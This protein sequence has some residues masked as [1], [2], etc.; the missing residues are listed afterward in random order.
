MSMVLSQRRHSM[1]VMNVRSFWVY[2]G[3]AAVLSIFSYK[4]IGCTTSFGHGPV[5]PRYVEYEAQHAAYE[6]WQKENAAWQASNKV[7]VEQ[8]KFESVIAGFVPAEQVLPRGSLREIASSIRTLVSSTSTNAKQKAEALI[9]LF[10][11][12]ERDERATRWMS[13]VQNSADC[14][15]VKEL[16]V[17]NS[18]QRLTLLLQGDRNGLT[19]TLEIPVNV[20]NQPMNP[21]V[22]PEEY[23]DGPA[24][25]GVSLADWLLFSLL[26]AVFFTTIGF[27]LRF[28]ETDYEWS[29][30]L[31]TWPRFVAGWL[32]K[33]SMAPGF[34]VVHGMYLLLLDAQPL[35]QW[36]NQRFSKRTFKDEYEQFESQLAEIQQRATKVDDPAF[37]ARIAKLQKRIEGA[38]NKEHIVKL[39]GSLVDIERYL[40]SMDELER[41]LGAVS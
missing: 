14:H 29:H 1:K 13:C 30:P 28:L 25:G 21:S 9:S 11:S 17:L 27:F 33:L 34:I 16:D 8:R 12:P 40:D 39:Q 5:N 24:V 18:S 38:Q 3:V 7:V 35:I 41:D 19:P 20:K 32:V 36:A 10:L 23:L 31:E 2:S 6:K 15:F 4:I 26:V 37:L 22:V